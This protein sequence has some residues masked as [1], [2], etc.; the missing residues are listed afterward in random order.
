MEDYFDCPACD[1]RYWSYGLSVFD[2][3]YDDHIC[4]HC[5]DELQAE[6]R[7]IAN[8]EKGDC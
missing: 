2:E 1:W 6:R 7:D 3:Q 4:E 8:A 5:F